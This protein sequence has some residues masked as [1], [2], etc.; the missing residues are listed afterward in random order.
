M[1]GGANSTRSRAALYLAGQAMRISPV[2]PR[3]RT[4]SL[5]EMSACLV[6][7]LLARTAGGRVRYAPQAKITRLDGGDFLEEVTVT[8]IGRGGY[9]S[10][11]KPMLGLEYCFIGGAE[12]RHELAGQDRYRGGWVSSRPTIQLRRR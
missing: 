7:R 1:I 6:D 2:V 5:T 9:P 8:D 12:P 11:A 3:P 4:P 10:Q